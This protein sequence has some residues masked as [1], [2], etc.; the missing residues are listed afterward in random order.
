MFHVTA[1][2]IAPTNVCFPAIRLVFFPTFSWLFLL[3]IDQIGWVTNQ[4]YCFHSS[5]QHIHIQCD[6]P[7]SINPR[8]HAQI[9]LSTR[10]KILG[11]HDTY[12]YKYSYPYTHKH[13][14]TLWSPQVT[15]CYIRIVVPCNMSVHSTARISQN[16]R[17]GWV[18]WMFGK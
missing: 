2:P 17:D 10:T 14:C 7:S 9:H 13:T 11:S 4:I 5:N 6:T 1:N 15:V 8:A 3:S 16:S 18:E 12:T